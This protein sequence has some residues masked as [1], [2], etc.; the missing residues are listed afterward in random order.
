MQYIFQL[1]H[2]GHA[3]GPH[4]WCC[5]IGQ[6]R[7]RNR[8]ISSERS[9]SSPCST[10]IVAMNFPWGETN[11]ESNHSF[12]H[13]H[14]SSRHDPSDSKTDPLLSLFIILWW[15]SPTPRIKSMV[16]LTRLSSSESSHS[17]SRPPTLNNWHFPE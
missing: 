15:D 4:S 11:D 2:P 9:T 6:G 3:S 14:F 1:S 10:G 13:L 12:S 17:P 16:F 5:C 8:S 7:F